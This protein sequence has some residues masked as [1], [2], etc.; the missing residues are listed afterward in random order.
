MNV[1]NGGYPINFD[2][3]GNATPDD[4]IVLTRC[5]LYIGLMQAAELLEKD[6]AQPGIYSLDVESQR[7]TLHAWIQNKHDHHPRHG[8]SFLP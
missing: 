1:L 3:K 2:R 6:N 7:Q 5:L 4:D 8:P